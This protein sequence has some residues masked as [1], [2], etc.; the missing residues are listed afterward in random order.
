METEEGEPGLEGNG[1]GKRRLTGQ[2]GDRRARKQLPGPVCGPPS[3]LSIRHPCIFTANCLFDYCEL[4][5][6]TTVRNQ[7]TLTLE[8]GVTTRDLQVQGLLCA[9]VY[10]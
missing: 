7:K 5:V 1:R 3:L 9:R 10:T 6:V 4:E 8:P 2:Q